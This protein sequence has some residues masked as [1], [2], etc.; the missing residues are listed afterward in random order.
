MTV[1]VR[2]AALTATALEGSCE[3]VPKVGDVQAGLAFGRAH[4]DWAQTRF[5]DL[6]ASADELADV[7]RMLKSSADAFTGQDQRTQHALSSI[8]AALGNHAGGDSFYDYGLP[9]VPYPSLDGAGRIA[10]PV[11]GHVG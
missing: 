5:E 4:Y 6:S 7:A 8:V 2:P 10:N 9:N 1:Q 11:A 3:S